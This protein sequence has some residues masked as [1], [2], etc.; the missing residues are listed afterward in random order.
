MDNEKYFSVMKSLTRLLDKVSPPLQEIMQPYVKANS[1]EELCEN[2]EREQ[3][4]TA[5]LTE[6]QAK[7][8]T[9]AIL[10]KLI[11][12][13]PEELKADVAADIILTIR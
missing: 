11:W 12:K 13:L 1:H 10:N 9:E 5:D 7:H 3:M 2:W 4:I 6:D 8:I